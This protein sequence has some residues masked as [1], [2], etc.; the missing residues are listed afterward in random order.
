MATRVPGAGSWSDSVLVTNSGRRPSVTVFDGVLRVTYERDSSTPGMAQDVV[1]VVVAPSGTV[2]EE[3]VVST[4][5]TER[6]DPVLHVSGVKHWLDW[7]HAADSFGLA[8]LEGGSWQV[9][10]EPTWPN[11]TW[12]GVEETRRGIARRVLTD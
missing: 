12:V 5:R 10:G 8:I 1:V 4:P 6:L 7:K 11:P 9:G 3:F 2:S